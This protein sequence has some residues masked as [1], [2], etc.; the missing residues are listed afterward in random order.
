[1]RDEEHVRKEILKLVREFYEIK[2]KNKKFIPGKTK[3][4]YAGR[5]FDE[6]EMEIMVDSILEFWLSMGRYSEEFEKEFSE[7]LKIKHI[8]VTNS[9]SSANLLAVSAL[10]SNQLENRLKPRDEVIVP[11]CSFPTTINPIIQNNL[12][13]VF[14]DADIKTLNM[15]LDEV[16]KAITD[17]TRMI[18]CLHNLGNPLDM[19]RIMEIAEENNLFVVEDSCDSLG[20]RFDRRFV[21]TF[22]DIGT[23]SFYPAH[24]V[25]MGGEG[26][27]VATNK[28]QLKEIL[29]SLRDWGRISTDDKA[30]FENRIK[31]ISYDRRYTY[32]NIGFNLKPTDV[33]VA[34]GIVQ[35]RKFPEFMKRRK[36][37]FYKLYEIF[38]RYDQYFVLPEAAKNSEPCWF[39]F[40]LTVKENRKFN[41][42]DIVSWLERNLIET[43]PILAGNITKQPAYLNVKFRTTG[44]LQNSDYIMRNSFFIGLYPGITDEM[45]DFIEEKLKEFFRGL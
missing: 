39:V 13:P 4:Q 32:V 18:M 15:N 3:I 25:G 30:R 28:Q 43:R 35:L 2:Y 26:G 44:K 33:Q 34:M 6:K 29:M 22:G 16:E 9:G 31:N 20:S 14:V 10:C 36:D 24:H 8:L 7:F 1:M 42:E 40:P 27:A 12:V 23:F 17:K 21:G 41:R 37:N 45:I 5:V 11:S 38:S 19:K